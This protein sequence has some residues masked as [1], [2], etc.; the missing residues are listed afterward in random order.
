MAVAL[1][2]S[3][4]WASHGNV[5][6]VT[7]AFTGT[8]TGTDHCL[9]VFDAT[10]DADAV[11]QSLITGVTYNG[12]PLTQIPSTIVQGLRRADMWYLVNPLVG[13]AANVVITYTSF[14]TRGIYG[15]A[16]FSGVDQTLPIDDSDTNA[17]TDDVTSIT[18]TA[19]VAGDMAI[20]CISINGA[21]GLTVAADGSQT[22][23]GNLML[24]NQVLGAASYLAVASAGDQAMG[25]TI[26]SSSSH[27]HVAALLR[28]SV[29]TSTFTHVQS[30]SS[31]ANAN[32][33]PSHTLAGAPTEGNL[34]VAGVALGNTSGGFTAANGYTKVDGG[35]DQT[36]YF[37]KVAGASEPAAQAPCTTANSRDWRC[38]VA[39][40]SGAATSS[41]L[42]I[43]GVT[44]DAT[45]PQDQA[46]IN[47]TDNIDTLMVGFASNDVN[48]TYTLQSIG[49]VRANER[50]DA[51]QNS[52]ASIT[53]FDRLNLT[54]HTLTFAAQATASSTPTN[55]AIGLLIFKAATGGGGGTTVKDIIMQGLIPFAR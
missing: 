20:N 54:T 42:D 31:G 6:S 8:D 43:S 5:T 47:P 21:S 2:N 46:A 3:S 9:V 16:L 25:F 34:L 49:G 40:Y 14:T 28:A 35:N 11:S 36:A 32:N 55:G 53:L 50:I 23:L 10:E 19:A 44:A 51:S 52:N 33:S 39:E 7:F 4:T 24:D 13:S 22:E 1:V 45:S 26:S 15:A 37:Y 30:G 18:L 17:G 48:R 27:A 29:R 41:P 38:A 12:V